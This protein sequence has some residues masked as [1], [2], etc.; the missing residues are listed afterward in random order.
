[1]LRSPYPLI[2]TIVLQNIRR[3]VKSNNAVIVGLDNSVYVLFPVSIGAQVFTLALRILMFLA[4]AHGFLWMNMKM[5]FIL[6]NISVEYDTISV[7][8]V[9][10]LILLAVAAFEIF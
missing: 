1:L 4:A 10:T 3:L 2:Q 6:P 9:K 7:F 8:F 5:C